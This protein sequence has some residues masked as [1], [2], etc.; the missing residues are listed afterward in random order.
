MLEQQLKKVERAN[1]DPATHE[2]LLARVNREYVTVLVRL[3]DTDAALRILKKIPKTLKHLGN[4]DQ[5]SH[6]LTLEEIEDEIV[7]DHI[8]MK[9]VSKDMSEQLGISHPY[10]IRTMSKSALLQLKGSAVVAI[11]QAE[12][13]YEAALEDYGNMYAG[14]IYAG[15][16]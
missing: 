5:A 8:L 9:K 11:Q 12:A 4:I 1:F 10:T 15:L 2:R 6:K 7:A 13:A 3:G 14:T 16:G